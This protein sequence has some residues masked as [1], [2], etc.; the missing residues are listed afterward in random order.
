RAFRRPLTPEQREVFIE[1]HFRENR[2]PV[3]ALKRAVLLVLKSPRFLYRE[4]GTGGL[5]GFDVASRLSFGLWDSVPDQL[6]WEAVTS[7]RLSTRE[8]VADQ[9][10]RMVVDLRAR[11]KLHEFFHQWLRVHEGSEVVKDPKL[12]PGFDDQVVSDLRNSLE[13]FL[14]DVIASEAAD[15]R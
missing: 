13:L 11:S 9:A 15:F 6:L 12:F 2:D 14:S 5:D 8:Q 3:V 1:E 10:R 7:G 4:L